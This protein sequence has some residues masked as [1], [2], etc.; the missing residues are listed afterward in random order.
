MDNMTPRKPRPDRRQSSLFPG[1]LLGGLLVLFLVAFLYT[2]YLFLGWGRALVADVPDLPALSLP[3]LVRSVSVRRPAGNPPQG[4]LSLPQDQTVQNNPTPV[5][6]SRVTVLVM[7]VDNRPDEPVARTDTII[8]LTINPETGSAGM[9]SLP[10]D[11]LVHVSALNSDVKI[12]TVHVLGEIDKY[13]GGGPALLK[14]TVADLTGYPVDYYVRVRFDGF[15]Q[16]IDLLGG[17]DIDVPREIRDD[18]YPDNNYGYDPLY[19]PA[20]WQHM[21]G[22]LALKYARTRHIDDDYGRARRQQ[23]VI[24]AIKNRVMETGE[25]AALLPRL[26]G[27]SIALANTVQTDMPVDKALAL[28]RNLD[29]V[30]LDNPTRIVIDKTMGEETTDPK[31]G[32]VLVPD[33]NKLQAAATALFADTPVSAGTDASPDGEAPIAQ[34]A[35]ARVVVLNGSPQDNLAVEAAALLTDDGYSVVGVGNA[36]R[37]DYIE[38]WLINHGDQAP[39]ACDLLAQKFDVKPDHIRL[40]SPSP[41]TDVTLILGADQETI[42]A[43]R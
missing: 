6:T 3:R 22:E 15:Q 5:A 35:Q 23:Q 4:V 27:L 28:A 8:L 13:P 30:N 24:M 2:G 43:G 39:N 40:D 37:S 1:L 33:T 31:L 11:L 16:I 34:V 29:Q 18:L 14:E 38:S 26:P 7:G 41:D 36:E 25:L 10:R 12:N 17:I 20:G 32:F 9:L 21:D 19:I 42:L